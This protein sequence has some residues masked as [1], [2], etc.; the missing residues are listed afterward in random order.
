MV[1][2]RIDLGISTYLAIAY[3]DGD[4]ELYPGNTRKQDRHYFT[5]AEYGTEG[6]NGPSKR[7]LRT[8]QTL[9][10]RTEHFL[11]AL[12]EHVVEQCVEHQVGHIAIGDLGSIREDDHGDTRQWGTSG[13]KKL[14]GWEFDRF[15][16]LLEYK[17]EARGILVDRVSER[18]TSKTC[19]CCGRERNQN[20]VERGTYVC[21]SCG[22]A[23]NADVNGAVNIR[24]QITRS[25]P[26]E[27]TSNGRLARPGTYLFDQTSGQFAPRTQVCCEP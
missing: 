14:H 16:R 3:D 18:G 17:A 27:D 20:R 5:R 6:E 26:L 24:R 21:D 10:R 15:T 13:N 7:A 25:P 8:R 23:M 4:A 22:A 1:N 2:R 11:H 9:S 12:S 19:S